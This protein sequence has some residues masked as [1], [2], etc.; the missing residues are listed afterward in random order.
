M[1]QILTLPWFRHVFYAT[2]IA[3][4]LILIPIAP[5]AT[6]GGLILLIFLPGTQLTR[7][8]G[9]APNGWNFKNIALSTALG[10]V[11]SPIVIYWSSLLFGFNRWTVII[12]FVV[13][14]L[15]MAAWI[16]Y[17]PP[18][19][20][21]ETL[22]IGL[23]GAS[24]WTRLVIVLLMGITAV[25]VYLAYFELETPQGYY[26]VQMEDW[27]KHYGVAFALRYTGVPPTSMFFY[28]MFPDEPLIYYYFL[29]LNGATLDLLQSGPPFL[30]QTFVTVIVLA[31]LSFSSVVF[32][33]A[34]RLFQQRTAAVWSLAFAT[35]IGGLDVI[36]ILHRTIEKYRD[37]FPDGPIPL[38]VYL[39]REHIDN[40]VS[41]LS[42]RLNTF[43]AHHVWVP[44]HLTALTIV[45]LGCLIYLEVKDRRK[46]LIILPVLL[47][48]LLGHSTWI[49]VIVAAALFLFALWQ[50]GSTYRDHGLNNARQLFF[51]YALIAVAF[52]AIAAPFI[53]GLIGPNAPKSGIAFV[54]PTL[55]SWAILRPFQATFGNAVWARILDLPLHFFIEMGALLVAGL[56]GL[57]LN[58][59]RSAVSRQPS[60][61]SRQQLAVSG[62]QLAVSGQRSAVSF[63]QQPVNHQSPVSNLQSPNRPIPTSLLPF[64]TILLT[65]GFVIVSFF[66]S[67]RGWSEIGLTLN[68]DL[69]LRALMPGQLVLA[70]FAGYFMVRLFEASRARAIKMS[71]IGVMVALIAVGVLNPAWEFVAMDL[72]KYWSEPQLTTEVYQTLRALPEVTVPQEKVLPVVQHRLHRNASRFQLSLGSRP[73]GFSTG[74]AVVFHP[75]VRDI[76]LA[77]ELSQQAFDNGLPVWSYQMFQNLGADYI[78]VGPAEREAMRHPEKYAHKTYF[79]PVFSQGDFEIYQVNPPAYSP[80]QLQAT[81]DHGAIEFLGQ[82]TD[83]QAQFP[84][85]S[86]D[87]AGGYGFVTAWRLAHSTDKNYTVFVHLVDAKGNIVA[88]ADHQLWAWDVKSE[89][90]TATWTPRL[91]HLDI[92]AVPETALAAGS[93]LTIR[94]GLWLPDTGEQFVAETPSLPVD[95][96]GRLIVGDLGSL[97]SP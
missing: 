66:A 77:H 94:L 76:A 73:I 71:A 78:F 86:S 48:A 56:G 84:G 3:L 92:T 55:D 12:V 6:V 18:E 15:A 19:T 39:P 35:V 31:S 33:L 58:F 97:I 67:G 16:S 5:V 83:P 52:M 32:L 44:Q 42:L 62:Q 28:G 64:F 80:D 60:A 70:L 50:I 96:N 14:I 24:L 2:L 30:H 9:L 82:F 57:V 81:F 90:P 69:G 27:Q 88:Q 34:Q 68:N 22:P 93:S 65:L 7:R 74:E 89:G 72:A 29:H 46:L 40:W 4:G 43:Y 53:A 36:P 75:D 26:P 63:Q 95:P 87:S 85:Q 1:R 45:C 38:G 47:F 61:V 10:L 59:Q 11:T 25:G 79:Q 20:T 37:N 51:G 23:D 54:I 8:L 49:A 41:A 13:Y 17:R 91:V 21:D